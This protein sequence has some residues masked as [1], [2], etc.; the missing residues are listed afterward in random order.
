M[1]DGG[2]L[3]E[4]DHRSGRYPGWNPEQSHEGC[5]S[6]SYTNSDLGPEEAGDPVPEVCFTGAAQEPET[7]ET[8]HTHI[9]LREL[10]F[11]MEPELFGSHWARILI[12][13]LV[14]TAGVCLTSL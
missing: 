12:P 9:T 10:S 13:V 11:L 1:S 2:E 7:P 4:P 6:K 3:E 5:V 8:R 14:L